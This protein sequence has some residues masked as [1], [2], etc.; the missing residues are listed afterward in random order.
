MTEEFK[1]GRWTGLG[2]ALLRFALVCGGAAAAVGLLAGVFALATGHDVSST[3]AVTY[4][5][6]GCGLFLVGVFPTGG[7]SL[8]R[9]TMSRRRPMGA[10]QEPIFLVGIV[11][12]GLGVLADIYSF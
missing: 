4:Y 7:F 8:V 9:G 6:I 2:E 5:L 1:P 12:I 3:L 11:L 10:R